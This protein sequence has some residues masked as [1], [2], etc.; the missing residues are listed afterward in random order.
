M[1]WDL[2]GGCWDPRG[3][4]QNLYKGA[5]DRAIFDFLWMIVQFFILC[6]AG[7]NENSEI[8]GNKNRGN[9][10]YRE[11]FRLRGILVKFL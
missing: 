2:L 10:N 6:A 11:T 9:H 4:F 7:T 8:Q 5:D 3:C 1:N